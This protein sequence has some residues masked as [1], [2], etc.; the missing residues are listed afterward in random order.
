MNWSSMA[1]YDGLLLADSSVAG[2]TIFDIRDK[3][4]N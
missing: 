4:K 1:V 2:H 3:D